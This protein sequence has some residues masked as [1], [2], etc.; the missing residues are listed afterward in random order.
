AREIRNALN[1]LGFDDVTVTALQG[2]ATDP[3]EYIIRFNDFALADQDLPN[4][5]VEA[6]FF[7]SAGA[8]LEVESET[9][10][11]TP[12]TET[13]EFSPQAVAFNLNFF[14]RHYK[15]SSQFPHGEP[16]FGFGGV[17]VGNFDEATGFLD[18]G[19]T[20]PLFLNGFEEA[21]A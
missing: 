6:N 12:R 10:E 9:E 1:Q 18:V 17:Q 7:N 21:N 11:Y 8:A 14:S 4:L 13:G 5:V 3:F 2:D 19:G 16:F 20:G 15:V